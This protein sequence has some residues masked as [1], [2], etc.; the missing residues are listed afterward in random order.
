M[1]FGAGA[2][3]LKFLL[4]VG[5]GMADEPIEALGGKTP[6]EAS[7][8]PNMDFFARNGTVGL[9]RTVPQGM[10]PGSDV[11]NMSLMGCAPQAYYTGRAPLEAL[12]MGLDMEPDDVAFRCNLVTL[13]ERSGGLFMSDYS[14][15]G[16]STERAKA[17]IAALNERLAGPDFAFYP[18]VAYRHILLWRGGRKRFDGLETTPPHDI[19]GQPVDSHLPSGAG[20]EVLRRLMGEARDLLRDVLPDRDGDGPAETANGIWLWGQGHRPRMPL[21]RERFGVR[22]VVISAVDLIKGLG[23]CAGLDTI[24]VPGATGD[25]ATNYQGKAYA[26]LRALREVDFVFLHVEAPDEASHQGRLHEK[27]AAIERL[28]E[29]VLGVLRRGLA[30]MEIEYRLLVLPDHLTPLRIRTHTDTPVPFLLYPEE[31]GPAFLYNEKEAERSGT[32]LEDGT[33]ILNALFQQD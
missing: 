21:L 4:V 14:G 7:R 1:P 19:L 2:R 15:G 8:T 29:E 11:A 23:L 20:E 26:A 17:C 22:G 9:V 16:I 18:G 31:H 30:K 32:F 6:L 10:A 33:R 13:G 28:D 5:D 12:S 25:L 24:E 27:V 3:R